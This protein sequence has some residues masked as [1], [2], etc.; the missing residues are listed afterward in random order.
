VA[1][2]QAAAGEHIRD[3]DNGA[4][5]EDPTPAG[6]VR[7][8]VDL[9]R[10]TETLANLGRNAAAY[11]TSLGWAGIVQRFIQLLNEQIRGQ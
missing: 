11:A 1:Y 9:A 8:A 10:D 3:G 2:K 5:A 4:L 6:F 7:R